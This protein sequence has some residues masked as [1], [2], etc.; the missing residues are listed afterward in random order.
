MPVS[1]KLKKLAAGVMPLNLHAND[2]EARATINAYHDTLVAAVDYVQGEV[3][4]VLSGLIKTTKIEFAVVGIFY[5]VHS[6]AVSTQKLTE[7]LDYIALGGIARTL[8]EL[9]LD[10]RCF[11]TSSVDEKT[12]NQYHAFAEVDRFK[13]A[14]RVVDLASKSPDSLKHAW[15]THSN[16]ASWVNDQERKTRIEEIAVA[17]WGK[18]NDGK[19]SW[20][21]HWSGMSIGN[22]AKKL[23]PAYELQY[24]EWYSFL[25]SYTHSGN[26]GYAD[27]SME[28]LESIHSLCLIFI[29]DTYLECLE[30]IGKVIP[31]PKAIQSFTAAREELRKLPVKRF[32]ERLRQQLSI[33][34]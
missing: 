20:P 5:Q 14:A 26:S 31:L 30:L 17:L 32:E 15:F 7:A 34:S 28:T 16:A 22:R 4:P 8:F 25:C 27:F 10:M 12:V 2:S 13:K 29:T 3:V 21:Q 11:S 1:D 23:G 19:V 9:S 6:L 33:N 24:R 18:T